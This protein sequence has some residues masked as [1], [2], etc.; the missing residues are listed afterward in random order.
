M[1]THHCHT[2]FNKHISTHMQ[3]VWV[4]QASMLNATVLTLELT[5][6]ANQPI[7]FTG[8]ASQ[9]FARALKKDKELQADYKKLTGH[10]AKSE[11]RL[12]WATLEVHAAEKAAVKTKAHSQEETCIGT[13]RPV[14]KIWEAE[15][16]DSEGF[17]APDGTNPNHPQPTSIKSGGS[18]YCCFAMASAL[19]MRRQEHLQGVLP[20]P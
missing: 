16:Q 17:Q 6:E 1:H 8:A 11:F 12:K 5:L 4:N 18:T 13:Y 10:V 14:R 2:L 15:G 20:Q 19:G 7:S 9:S 3:S